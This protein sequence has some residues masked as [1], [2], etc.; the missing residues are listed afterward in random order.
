MTLTT[1]FS[2]ELQGCHQQ[3]YGIETV[4][5]FHEVDH[6]LGRASPRDS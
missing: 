6:S 5:G 3:N 1:V 4:K 2:N